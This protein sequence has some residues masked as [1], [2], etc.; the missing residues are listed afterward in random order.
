MS[1]TVCKFGGSSLC[2]AEMFRRVLD[3]IKSDANR[4]FIV[5]SAPGKRNPQDEKITDR[6]YRAYG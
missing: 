4:R 5:L 2:D 6:L 3:I 1:T